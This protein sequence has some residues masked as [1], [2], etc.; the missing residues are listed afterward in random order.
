MMQ[1]VPHCQQLHFDSYV[2]DEVYKEELYKE[3][4]HYTVEEIIGT[5]LG[6]N[7]YFPSQIAWQNSRQSQRLFSKREDSEEMTPE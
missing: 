3:F 4:P 7:P 1:R 5:Y 2:L 6:H